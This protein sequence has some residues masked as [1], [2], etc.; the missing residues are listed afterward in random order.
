A[1]QLA[2]PTNVCGTLA[3][4][5]PPVEPYWCW[6]MSLSSAQTTRGSR[7][8]GYG[9][10]GRPRQVLMVSDTPCGSVRGQRSVEHRDAP[11]T[12][13]SRSFCNIESLDQLA[14]VPVDDRP[15]ISDN[16]VVGIES[17]RLHHMRTRS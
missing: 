14:A 1:I 2:R 8:P 13:I 7:S 4:K 15:R 6:F 12:A 16:M 10:S 11:E 17:A 9:G 5:A 3:T